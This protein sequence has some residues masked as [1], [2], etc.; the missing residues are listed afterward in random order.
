M[1]IITKRCC[2]D[3]GDDDHEVCSSRVDRQ[4]SAKT[5]TGMVNTSMGA[6]VPSRSSRKVGSVSV[7]ASFSAA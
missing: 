7:T 5:L 6:M 2:E 4:R 3:E 1:A